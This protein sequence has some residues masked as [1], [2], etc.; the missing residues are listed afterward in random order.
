MGLYYYN[1]EARPAWG[2]LFVVC[3]SVAKAKPDLAY[4]LGE[5]SPEKRKLMRKPLTPQPPQQ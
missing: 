4:E 1:D 2:G 3:S 5:A